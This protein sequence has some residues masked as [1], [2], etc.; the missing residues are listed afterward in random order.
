M[1]NFNGSFYTDSAQILTAQNR[2]LRFGDGVFETIRAVHGKIFFWEEHYLR[3]MASMRILRMDIPMSFTM[4]HLEEEI[5]ATLKTNELEKGAARIRVTVFRKDDGHYLPKERGVDYIIETTPLESLFYTL[6]EVDYEIELYKDHYLAPDLLSTLKSA[7]RLINITGSIYADENGYKNC[8]LLNTDKNVV[9]A[10]NGNVFL[11][12]DNIVK[13]PPLSDGCLNG[14]IRKQ[15][16]TIVQKTDGLQLEET[17]VSPFEL[18]KADE[19]FITNTI[20]GITPVT[21]YRKKEYAHKVA[22]ELLGKLN[23]L[24]RLA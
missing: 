15:I 21:K 5:K 23:A 20:N 17:S 7:N 22:R 16:I 18:Q 9:E 14:I 13:T 6:N 12:K 2:G 3:L 24:T 1:I 11:V 10:L 4:E 8:L 19:I